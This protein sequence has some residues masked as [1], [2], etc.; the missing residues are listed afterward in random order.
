MLNLDT[1]ILLHAFV[2]ELQKKE[3]Q[4]LSKQPW[5]ISAIV[6]WEVCKLAQINRIELDLSSGSVR[7]KLSSIHVWPLSLDICEMSTRLDFKSD[8]ADELI[9]ATSI[10]HRVPLVTRDEKILKS[11]M[12]PFALI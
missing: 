7:S 11:K 8:P 1:H 4:L 12:I 10:I 3:L 9:A 6:L 5:G 2:G